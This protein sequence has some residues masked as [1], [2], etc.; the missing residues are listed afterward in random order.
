MKKQAAKLVSLILTFMLLSACLCQSAGASAG[1]APSQAYT[2]LAETIAS[3]EQNVMTKPEGYWEPDTYDYFLEKYEYAKG[4][5]SNPDSTDDDYRTATKVLKEARGQLLQIYSQNFLALADV[6]RRA[7]DIIYIPGGPEWTDES[8]GF[9]INEYEYAKGVRDGLDSTE[10]DYIEA[11]E[12][13]SYAIEQ[14]KTYNDKTELGKILYQ[15]ES[16]GLLEASSKYT[17]TNYKRFEDAYSYAKGLEYAYKVPQEKID[18]AVTALRNAME[19]L[20]L[21]GDINNDKEITIMDVLEIQKSLAGQ[22]ELTPAALEAADTDRSG[23]IGVN[24][25]LIIQKY[26]AKLLP[27]LA[28]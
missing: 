9:L 13:L 27:D 11:K 4:V 24:D 2:E 12:R 14:L 16:T 15:V 19:N 23:E 18:E 10:E 20:V 22:T 28:P 5:L 1:D 8:R 17:Q 26:I 6:V 7:E 3:A 25:C 21:M